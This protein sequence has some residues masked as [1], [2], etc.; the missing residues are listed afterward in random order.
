MFVN[1]D[2]FFL[3]ELPTPICI[4]STKAFNI[5]FLFRD[6]LLLFLLIFC[7]IHKRI[8]KVH[9]RTHHNINVA[10]QHL[11]FF[12]LCSTRNNSGCFFY[13]RFPAEATLIKETQLSKVCLSLL[14][15]QILASLLLFFS[16][17]VKLLLYC[18]KVFCQLLEKNVLR[19]LGGFVSDV[20]VFRLEL[21]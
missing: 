10:C 12:I 7:G 16:L 4:K 11:H 3:G 5:N 8:V 13:Q 15:T 17:R 14:L 19:I 6:F 2:K 9:D 18:F 1:P 20:H 21:G